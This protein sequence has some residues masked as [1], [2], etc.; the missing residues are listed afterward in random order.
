MQQS[1]EN[2]RTKQYAKL[3]AICE[4][5]FTFEKQTIQDYYFVLG[6]LD[7]TFTSKYDDSHEN[8]LRTLVSSTK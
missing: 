2:K 1:E 5:H 4:V 6:T 3:S 8:V 7:K